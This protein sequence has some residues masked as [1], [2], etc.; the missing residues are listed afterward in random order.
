MLWM[1]FGLNLGKSI[2]STDDNGVG[3]W[4]KKNYILPSTRGMTKL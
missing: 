4:K 2:S 1:D 3:S